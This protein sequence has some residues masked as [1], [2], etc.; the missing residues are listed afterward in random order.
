VDVA[1]WLRGLGLERYEQAFRENDV[2][3]DLL[4]KLT[5]EDLKEIG[6]ASVG[7]RRRLL[8][9]IGA[10]RADAAPS[11]ASPTEAPQPAVGAER[12]QLTVMFVDLVGSTPLA[13]RLDP[14]ET[15]E[16]LGAYQDRVA[17][18]VTRFEGH[19]AKFMG[20]GVLAYFGWPAA[21][22]DEAERAVRA[23]LAAVAAVA[24]LEA[25]DGTRLAARVGIATGLVVVGEL[26]GGT[27]EA[28]ERA[29]TGETPNLAARLQALAPPG[30]V[31]A[32]ASTRRLL[33]E[34]FELEDLGP[35]AVK[36]LA[37]PIRAFRVGAER[38]DIGRFE[39]RQAGGPAPMVGR[40]QELALL[41]ERWRL[42]RDGKGQAVLLT[43]EPGI[44]KSRLV[45]ALSEALV[46]EPHVPIRWQCS[47]Y[48]VDSS[49][50]PVVRHL[51]QAACFEAGDGDEER[52]AKLE[53]L[54][55]ADPDEAAR[56]VP[57]LASLLGVEAGDRYPPLDL[58][59]QRRRAAT[60]EAL[61]RQLLAPARAGPVL[62][63]VEDVHWI[64]PTTLELVELLLGRVVASPV[65]VVLTA[66]P[67]FQE[68]L[69]AHAHLT[70]LGLTRLG[71]G[72]AAAIVGGIT[73]GRPLPDEVGA[74]I[75]RRTDGVPLFVEELTKAVLEADLL[76][77]RG[78]RYELAGPLPPLAIP[79]TLHD[80]LMARLDRLA[81]V[82]EVAQVAA[83]LGREFDH[84]LLAA[85]SPLG[86]AKLGAALDRL[87]AAELVF[88]RG[89]AP[90]AVYAFKHALVRDAAYDSLLK[91]KRR[92]L[93]ARIATV[94]EERFPG[95]AEMQPE[96]LARHCTEA[97]LTERAVGH[98]Y[99][100]GR[101]AMARSATA[102]ALAQLTRGL[103]LLAVLP[104][105]PDRDRAEVD[106]RIALGGALIAAKGWAAPEV[107]EA[108]ERARELC[109]EETHLPQLLAALSGVYVHHLHRFGTSV[110]LRTA[111][112]L[113]RLA[114]R[115][116][117]TAAQVAGHR[118]VA[119]S[120]M[121]SGRLAAAVPHF[122]QA[123]ALYD[124]ADRTSPVYLWAPDS[125]VAILSFTALILL[126]RGYPDRAVARSQEALAAAH[127][128][129]HAY[130]TCHALFLNCWLHQLRGEAG[131]VRQRV[132]AAV[133]LATEHGLSA[134]AADR[135]VLHGWALAAEGEVAAGMAE[136]RQGFAA[137]RASG[138]LLFQPSFRGLL[139]DTC[140]RAG[141][142][143]EALALLA[144]ALAI[145]DKIEVRWFEA[146]LH[147][148]KGEA[149]LRTASADA[150]ESEACF[151]RAIDVAR[152]QGAR[153]W[154]LRA[155]TS[156][157]RLW[158]ERGERRRAHDLLA[159]VHAW[160]TEGAD[161]SS[162]KSAAALL[163]SLA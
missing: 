144:E 32:A 82:K 39:A 148:L 100:A 120:A 8:E 14:E 29:V 131:I 58:T 163:D 72:D 44:G 137:E 108:Y 123:L 19:V 85:V 33:G 102:E 12:R 128:L 159:P 74:E 20:D 3:A 37:G 59:P 160:F 101:Q 113:L 145:V 136:L 94:L 68:H 89:A 53:A 126:W 146:E 18:E 83:C 30:G 70:R 13:A 121:F 50:W 110:A 106:L 79:S 67:E 77:D 62:L 52:L 56:A 5:A 7:H 71:R 127:E 114:E 15:G 73:G 17:G 138:V 129:G 22:E 4:A 38:G 41:L 98:W 23:G 107:G 99:R 40:D 6:V 31:V 48:H 142:A 158:A 76:R 66:R 80:S 43:G 78:D 105:G 122:E 116:Q 25:P 150:A 115:Q 81:P 21:H 42:A 64:D 46:G 125:R 92:Q 143:T 91:S 65:L 45:C 26:V 49:L 36:G 24:R 93:H 55:R 104:G 141:D 149:L 27:E 132:A 157:A 111:E 97:G 10:L 95:T 133:A 9:A 162:L 153:W 103:E 75:V 11:P 69:G 54:L 130:T 134:W 90:G 87:V 60:L 16:L 1:D 139:A 124:P 161:T 34:V 57:L 35:L 51:E 86:A 88:R 151:G 109:N 118:F 147:R 135:I 155:A 63:L 84:A 47:P 117:D 112:E 28:R 119:V 96:V 152:Q 154:E 156:L 61:E 140:T 2:E